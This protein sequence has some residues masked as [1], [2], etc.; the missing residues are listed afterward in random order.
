MIASK[1]ACATTLA[2]CTTVAVCTYRYLVFV[3]LD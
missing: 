2:V 1:D 3:G